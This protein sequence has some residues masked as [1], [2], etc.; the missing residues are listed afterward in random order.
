MAIGAHSDAISVTVEE[1]DDGGGTQ[2]AAFRMQH[3][4]EIDVRATY[5]VLACS[6]LLHPIEGTTNPLQSP[7]IVRHVAACQTYEGGVGA[8]LYNEA[9][10]PLRI[11]D[12]IDMIDVNDECIV[13]MA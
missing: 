7:T 8:E 3:D 5:C 10:A 6:Y 11:L 2:R 9:V 12:K 13:L 4:G 1:E